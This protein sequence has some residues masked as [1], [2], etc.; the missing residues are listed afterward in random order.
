MAY[1]EDL[2]NNTTIID[3]VSASQVTVDYSHHEVHEGSAYVHR[4]AHTVLKAGV[5]DHLIVTPD[6]AR[7]S[8]M[9]IGVEAIGSTIEVILY[10]D[11]ITSADGTP[12][13]VINRNRNHADDNTTTVFL[14]PTITNVGTPIS[15]NSFG[16]GRNSAGGGGRDAQ[17]MVLRQGTKY[18]LRLIE[19]DIEAT[20]INVVLD[21]YEHTNKYL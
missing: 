11:T 8:H 1:L 12:M 20:T 6:T 7:W 5:L 18:L 14:T 2:E 9:V 10:E 21:W 17:E 3:K 4:S 19:A 13:T 16:A 15:D